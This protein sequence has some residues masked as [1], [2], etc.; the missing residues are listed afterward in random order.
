MP[1]K[2]DALLVR[3]VELGFTESDFVA[4]ALAAADQAGATTKNQKRIADI[5]LRDRDR[6]IG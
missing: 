6:L 2:V 3:A 4:L 1:T 5:L